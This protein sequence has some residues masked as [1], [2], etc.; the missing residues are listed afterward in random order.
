MFTEVITFSRILRILKSH[1]IHVS[2]YIHILDE[3]AS[4]GGDITPPQRH[5]LSDKNASNR[6][7]NPPLKLLI[8]GVKMTEKT[9]WAIAANLVAS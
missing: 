3:I 5:R 4:V 2:L 1:I 8:S 9:I 6:Y 7:E